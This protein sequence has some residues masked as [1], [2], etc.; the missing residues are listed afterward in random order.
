MGPN[1]G[2]LIAQ[3]PQYLSPTPYDDCRF[4][5]STSSELVI[6]SPMAGEYVTVAWPTSHGRRI[7]PNGIKAWLRLRGLHWP[8]FCS[9]T[10]EDP[11]S[12]STQI[13]EALDGRVYA[14]CHSTPSKCGFR[15]NLSELYHSALLKSEFNHLPTLTVNPAGPDMEVLL[16]A[17]RT[18]SHMGRAPYFEG[19]CG[20]HETKYVGT[21]QLAG[22]SAVD[23][24]LDSG[25]SYR[26]RVLPLSHEVACHRRRRLDDES[27]C[28]ATSIPVPLPTSY[29]YTRRRGRVNAI[30]GPS[31]IC[32]TCESQ[33][34]PSE[35]EEDIL[36]RLSASD[37]VSSF[38][39]QGLIDKCD[40]CHKY[41]L[42]SHLRVHIRTCDAGF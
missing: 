1:I 29:A 36:A 26:H 31:V 37:G 42:S 21:V 3:L 22:A 20:E 8:C 15:M 35:A 28:F 7:Q 40:L 11:Q 5:Q 38:E 39:M 30:A 16:T 24:T 19:Y 2:H 18:G 23:R 32:P 27:Q 41:F 10:S 33:G 34:L 14:L 6:F 12:L 9:L 13:V 4:F 17:F 25:L